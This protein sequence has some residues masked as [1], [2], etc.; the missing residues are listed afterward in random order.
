MAK[1]NYAD[2]SSEEVIRALNI[3]ARIGVL[4]LESG[5]ASFRAK[6]MMQRVAAALHVNGLGIM[7]T[8]SIILT[9]A[10]A[11]HG[12]YTQILKVPSL[13]VNMARIRALDAL[14]RQIDEETSAVQLAAM[15]DSIEF[16]APGYTKPTVIVAVALACGAFAIILGGGA[17]EF[18]AAATGA[19][20]AQLVRFGM[21]ARHF[22]PYLIT[23]VGTVVATIL[24]Y[25]LVRLLAAPFPRLGLIASV[26]LFVPGMPLVTALLDLIHLDLISAVTR[27]AYAVFLVVNI[28]IGMLLVLALTNFSI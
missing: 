5:T 7:V 1:A 17:L 15:L 25:L 20:A 28:A 13:G 9:T 4:A 23:G 8:P 26:L 14:S 10:P 27:G 2:R 24:S 16:A 6:E 21:I 3:L 18:I 22:S 19:A 11:E 12:S